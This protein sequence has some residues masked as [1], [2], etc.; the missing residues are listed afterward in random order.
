MLGDTMKKI[1]LLLII[2][3]L[4]ITAGCNK[5]NDEN[6]YVTKAEEILSSMTL[7][8]KVW[9]LFITTPEDL[10]G[11]S[12]VVAAGE[13]SKKAIEKYPVGGLIYFDYNLK[14]E[15]QTKEMLSNIQS[16]SKIPLFTGV[17]EEGGRV[18]RVG[19]NEKMKVTL[20]PPMAEVKDKK[21]A[22]KIGKTLG[23]ELSALGFNLDFAPVADI[24][25]NE[26]NSEIGNRSFGSDPEEAGKLAAKVVKGLKAKNMCSVL[27]HFPG[28]GSTYTDS[29]KGYSESTRTLKQLRE[30]EF[31]PFKMGIEEGADFVLL[32][33]MTLINS[34]EKVPSSI[35]KSICDILKNELGFKGIIIT[36]SFKMGAISDNYSPEAAAVEAIKAG[37]D[38]ILMPENLVKAHEGIINAVKSGEITEERI[39]ESVLKIL[40]KKVEKK[41]IK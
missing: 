32:S 2:L 35:S 36:D 18:S 23:K 24:I 8:E 13:A 41:I 10:T 21:T 4:L 26:K 9:Q 27:K 25:V 17:D 1:I 16:Y 28:H 33:H 20:H 14:D 40:D 7:S 19:A 6:P 29:H 15:K 34:E 38:I 12:R 31:I 3:S 39:N 37:V 5:V 22:Y 11:V 30:N